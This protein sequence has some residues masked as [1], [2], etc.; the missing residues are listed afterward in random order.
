LPDLLWDHVSHAAVFLYGAAFAIAGS[1]AFDGLGS[2][3]A[4]STPHI[5]SAFGTKRTM[6]PVELT[7]AF[8]PNPTSE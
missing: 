7:S 1:I 2:G 3:D 8:D 4:N 5:T 6:A